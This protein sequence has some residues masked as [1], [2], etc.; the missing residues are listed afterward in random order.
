MEASRCGMEE[1]GNLVMKY[2]MEYGC[3]G[4]AAFGLEVQLKSSRNRQWMHHELGNF[5]ILLV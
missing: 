1:Q 4:Q 2:V 5:D 3:G